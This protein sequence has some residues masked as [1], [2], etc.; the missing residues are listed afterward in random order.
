[1]T[2]IINKEILIS[3]NICT[4]DGLNEFVNVIGGGNENFE[5]PINDAISYIRNMDLDSKTK[6]EWY[7]FVKQFKESIS[8]YENQGAIEMKEKYHVFNTMTGQYEDATSLDG[9]RQIQQRI[10]SEY[11]AANKNLFNISQEAYIP[12]EDRSLWKVIE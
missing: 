7:L 5:M 4:Q 3:A 2:A 12:E 11:I 9:A 1:M 10:I 8:F 6:A